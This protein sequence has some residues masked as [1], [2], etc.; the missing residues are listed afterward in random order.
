MQGRARD[1]I[2]LEHAIQVATGRSRRR[3]CTRRTDVGGDAADDRGAAAVGDRGDALG[4]APLQQA[5]DIGLRRAGGRRSPEG[6]SNDRE[7]R[8]RRRSRTC[9]ARATR[10]RGRRPRRCRPARLAQ[11]CAAAGS[12]T[13][14]SGTGSSTSPERDAPER[15]TQMGGEPAAASRT[16]AGVGCWSSKPQPQC[17]RRRMFTEPSL[18]SL[19]CSWNG[20]PIATYIGTA[21][22]AAAGDGER[23]AADP[24]A[25]AVAAGAGEGAIGARSTTSPRAS[26]RRPP[27][28]RS[29]R[30]ANGDRRAT[31]AWRRD[32]STTR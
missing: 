9:R 2:D 26:T 10:A 25:R 12:S 28:P 23:A 32:W 14:S 30:C 22:P 27:T 5:L 11:R 4:R 8:A 24:R 3:R 15:G 16:S 18:R 17:L 6:G 19:A 21:T 7:S 13:A 1:G 31:T 20:G 29:T